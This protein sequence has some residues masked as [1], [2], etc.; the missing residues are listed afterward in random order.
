MALALH[1]LGALLRVEVVNVDGGR[2]DSGG[3]HVATVAEPDFAAALELDARRGLLDALGKHVHELDL[4]G[5][6]HDDV[7]TR[8]VEGNG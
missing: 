1:V 4:V 5:E 6:S 7:E 2:V 8:G 3:E